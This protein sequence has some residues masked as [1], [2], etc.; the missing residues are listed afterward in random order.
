MVA[1]LPRRLGDQVMGTIVA[2]HAYVNSE[3]ACVAW[4]LDAKIDG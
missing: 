1:M 4:D 2:A 3:V